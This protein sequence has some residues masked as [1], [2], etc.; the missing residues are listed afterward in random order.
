M[1]TTTDPPA[2]TAS[3]TGELFDA[4]EVVDYERS[5]LDVLRLVLFAVGT[6]VVVL[7]N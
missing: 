7:L 1:T 6:L 2:E 4:P 5:P 3:A